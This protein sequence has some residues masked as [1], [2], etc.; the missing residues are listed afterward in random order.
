M[1]ANLQALSATAVFTTVV[2]AFLVSAPAYAGGIGIIGSG[3]AHTE[4]V[5]FYSRADTETFNQEEPVLYSN[6]DDYEQFSTTQNVAQFGGG[7]EL[8]L[9]DRD[10]LINGSCRVYYQQDAP[11]TDPATI[12]A[13]VDPDYV[14]AAY[15]EKARHVGVGLIGLNFGMFEFAS[16]RMRFGLV[17]HIGSGFITTDHT[18]YFIASVGP[19]LTYKASRRVHVFGDVVYQARVRTIASHSGNIYLGARYYFD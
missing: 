8:L 5:F 14:V 1:R 2:G 10:D 11:Q 17:G 4:R 18:D 9:G 16:D 6:I 13:I 19:S 15:R 7:L 12:T 3:G